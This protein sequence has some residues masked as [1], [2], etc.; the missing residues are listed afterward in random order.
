MF[1]GIF[2]GLS[3]FHIHLKMFII[4][5]MSTCVYQ[6]GD[7]IHLEDSGVRGLARL[8]CKVTESSVIVTHPKDGIYMDLPYLGCL[9]FAGV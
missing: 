6:V 4:Y 5:T 9:I 8:S 1:Y 7:E 3:L 2:Y